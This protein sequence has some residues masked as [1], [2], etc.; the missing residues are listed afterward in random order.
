MISAALFP[1][2]V[3]TPVGEMELLTLKNWILPCVPF[4]VETKV[5]VP[6]GVLPPLIVALFPRVKLVVE[7][8]VKEALVVKVARLGAVIVD[9]LSVKLPVLVIKL[10]PLKKFTLP[11]VPRVRDWPFCVPIT[12]LPLSES[13][14]V[15]VPE[16]EAVGVPPATLR[17]PNFALAVALDPS[18]R[19]SVVFL[20][21]IVPLIVFSAKGEPPFWVGKIPVISVGPPLRLSADDERVPLAFV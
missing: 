10:L 3:R 8:S 2:N 5:N 15:P 1:V 6:P 20:S 12:P 18:K 7:G 16:I 14:F 19:S 11:V 4:A 17:N 9:P 13:A 21:K